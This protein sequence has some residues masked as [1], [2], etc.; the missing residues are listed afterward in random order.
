MS[1]NHWNNFFKCM[2]L[3]SS[4][5]SH[6]QFFINNIQNGLVHA[7]TFSCIFRRYVLQ[8]SSGISDLGEVKWQ[9]FLC[10]L[11]AWIIIY[12]CSARGIKSSGKVSKII[13]FT[14]SLLRHVVIDIDRLKINSSIFLLFYCFGNTIGHFYFFY[15]IKL[16]V[17]SPTQRR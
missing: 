3:I 17:D 14:I 16:M 11:L 4:P 5:W 6:C 13:V 1:Y 2:P 12:V 15:I 7:N 8:L 10:Y 9:L